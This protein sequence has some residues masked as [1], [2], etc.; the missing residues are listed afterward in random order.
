MCLSVLWW[1]VDPPPPPSPPQFWARL[2]GFLHRAF[3]VSFVLLFTA[4]HVLT[5]TRVLRVAFDDTASFA[6][7]IIL[8]MEQVSGWWC[9]LYVET[10]NELHDSKCSYA[11]TCIEYVDSIYAVC[12]RLLRVTC[13]H[14]YRTIVSTLHCH[15]GEAENVTHPLLFLPCR[16]AWAWSPTLLFV[17]MPIKCSIRGRPPTQRDPPSGIGDR[18]SQ[19]WQASNSSFTSPLHQPS[20]IVMSIQG[21]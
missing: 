12:H 17:R 13:T 5:H 8:C 6:P 18:L 14:L 20:C 16:F 7:S 11:K 3:D 2:H 9:A 15:R 10:V 21:A 1:S 19:N 4:Y